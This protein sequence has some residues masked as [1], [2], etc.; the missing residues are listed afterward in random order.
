LFGFR[1]FAI[2]GAVTN[3]KTLCVLKKISLSLFFVCLF[4]FASRAQL[5]VAKLV[6]KDA[7]KYGL[8]YGLFAYLDFPLA[9]ENQSFRVEL[10]DLALF[11]SKGENLFTSTADGKGYISIKVGYKYVFSETQAGF[12]LLPSAGY[13]RAITVKEGQDAT[14][15][16]GIAGGLE[17][18][19]TL[20]VGQNGHTINFGLKYEYDHGNAT[21]I[22]QSVGL[23]I[24]YGF[25]LFRKKEN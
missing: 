10:M 22:I 2:F 24:S 13:C 12:Y 15:G 14:Y 3:Q 16:D 5:M 23:R 21:H 8:G 11:P 9:N 7:A 19:Y 4:S 1:F 20:E 6:G 25:G 18:G 17:G